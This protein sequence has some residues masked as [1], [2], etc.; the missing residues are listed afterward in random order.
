MMGLDETLGA[1]DSIEPEIAF[2]PDRKIQPTKYIDEPTERD[3]VPR[4]DKLRVGA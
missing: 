2:F 1:I 4:F 3:F